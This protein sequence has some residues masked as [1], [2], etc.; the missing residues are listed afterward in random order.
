MR[1]YAPTKTGRRAST[2]SA[3]DLGCGYGTLA[4]QAGEALVVGDQRLTEVAIEPVEQ[5]T[6]E[7]GAHAGVGRR[8]AGIEGL[9]ELEEPGGDEVDG[10]RHDLEHADRALVGNGVD[11]PAGL[12]P[13]LG[14][15][16]VDRQAVV[17]GGLGEDGFEVQP[18]GRDEGG[19]GRQRGNGRRA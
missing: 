18:F 9:V 12:G 15:D 17:P 14:E 1:V 10:L 19:G 4:P 6:H 13:G 16:E 11:P 7:P 8:I 2:L 5:M 3:Y